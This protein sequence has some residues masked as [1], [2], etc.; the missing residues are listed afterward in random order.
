MAKQ[1]TRTRRI[2]KK[3]VVLAL[4]AALV[5]ALAVTAAAYSGIWDWIIRPDRDADTIA[6]GEIAQTAVEQAVGAEMEMAEIAAELDDGIQYRF[7]SEDLTGGYASATATVNEAGRIIALDVSAAFPYP[8]PEEYP[9]DFIRYTSSSI[10]GP[11]LPTFDSQRWLMEVA[12]P[13]R[14]AYN[15]K[16]Q[17]L[18]PLAVD[19]LYGQGWLEASGKDIDLIYFEYFMPD[20]AFVD[21]LM[22]NG[23]LYFLYLLPD[24]GA[25]VGFYLRPAEE[26]QALEDGHT[27][28][29]PYQKLEAVRNGTLDEWQ[30]AWQEELA[31]SP[32]V[33]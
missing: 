9:D 22:Q 16:I 20:F 26:L 14:D 30:A 7:Y 33:G 11:F 23:D 6:R 17:G 32:G 24:D 18:A 2:G 4:A 15:E 10:D 13:D 3:A 5:A 21:V 25:P 31:N 29:T 28:N 8:E 27:V 19:W 1:E 12:Y